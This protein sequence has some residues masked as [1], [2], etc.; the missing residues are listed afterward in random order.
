M[1][2]VRAILARKGS[3][4]FSVSADESVANAARLMNDRSIGGLLVTDQGRMVGIFTE[5]DVLRRVVAERRDPAGTL[6]RDVMTMPVLF[7]RVDATIDECRSVMTNR[8]IRHLPVMQDEEPCG[9]V[10]I[11]DLLAF[12]VEEQADTIHH[13]NSYVF[14]VR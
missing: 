9:M 2:T 5:R 13:L 10:T 1:G 7:C 6:V 12:E 4:V 11:G 8:R 14:G 3:E